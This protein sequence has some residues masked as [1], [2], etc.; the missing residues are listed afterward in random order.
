MDKDE[1]ERQ[2]VGPR[3][4][5]RGGLFGAMHDTYGKSNLDRVRTF[6]GHQHALDRLALAGRVG[7]VT[8][9]DYSSGFARAG[10]DEAQV[11]GHK[12]TATSLAR[13]AGAKR[14]QRSRSR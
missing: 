2:P 5:E 10:G 3:Y 9:I 4:A 6:V 14:R 8:G 13:P 11:D 7:A 12:P 1:F